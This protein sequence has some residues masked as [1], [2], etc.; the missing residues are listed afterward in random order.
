MCE[1][2]NDRTEASKNVQDSKGWY[3]R[4][5][6]PHFDGGDVVQF[7]T[8]RLYDSLPKERLRAWKNEL[9]IYP[10][11]IA[12]MKLNQK[13]D[14]WLDQGYGSCWLNIEEIALLV[15][16]SLFYFDGEKYRLC[17]WVI[18]PN[19]VHVL[20]SQVL[21]FRLPD[22]IHSWKSYTAG[23]ANRLLHRKGK[24]WQDDY[25][26][27]FIRNEEHF[28]R[29]KYYIEENPVKAGLCAKKEDWRF[30]SAFCK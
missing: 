16:H 30:G 15:Q 8:F 3:F 4:G 27:R 20:F 10:K 13:I 14:T 18:M 17:S 1:M 5:Y 6:L 12:E 11:E 26:D 24:F 22:V 28:E 23:E 25:Y 21:G 7:V 2:M 19:H 9:K 29:V